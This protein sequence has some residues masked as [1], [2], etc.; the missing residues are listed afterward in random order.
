[1]FES[2]SLSR[3]HLSERDR[4][5]ELKVLHIEEFHSFIVLVSFVRMID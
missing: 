1:M 4:I 5:I 3:L 2:E